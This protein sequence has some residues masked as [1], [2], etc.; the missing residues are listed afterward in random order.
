MS[1]FTMDELRELFRSDCN[2]FTTIAAMLGVTRERVRQI[3][4]RHFRDEFGA[5]RTGHARQIICRRK[6]TSVA[7]KALRPS[8]AAL[9]V[10]EMAERRG[11]TV[12][13]V[14]SESRDIVYASSRKLFVSGKKCR[15]RVVSSTCRANPKQIVRYWHVPATSDYSQEVVIILAGGNVFIIPGAIFG[16][17]RSHYIP[18][19]RPS[20]RAG[21][22]RCGMAA[23]IDY[24]SYLDRWD[25]L[26]P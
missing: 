24:W 5:Y 21:A 19:D 10:A 17:L 7:R 22:R 11:L 3:Y 6:R 18:T 13:A 12:S 15:A 23:K 4:N 8:G 26:E 9:I 20:D 2:N 14:L 25:L 16:T 1:R